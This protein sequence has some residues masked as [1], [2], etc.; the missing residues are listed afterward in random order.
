MPS[1][2][3]QS[4]NRK[5]DIRAAN[6]RQIIAAAEALF[7]E[8]GFNGTST[9]EIADRAG[10][11]KANVH[12]YFKTKQDLYTVVLKD[13]LDAWMH[14]ASIFDISDDPEEVFRQ[15]IKAKMEHSFSRPKGSKV[16]A[17]EIIQ[18]G[19]V[20]GKEIKKALVTWDETVTQKIQ[21]WIDQGK[22]YPVQPQSLLNMIWSSTQYYADYDYQIKALNGNKRL[23]DSQKQHAI[24][25]VTRLILNGVL[26]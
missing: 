2:K 6:T 14:D 15:Y 12:Y 9:Q 4:K 7:A 13:I 21:H 24:D 17:M 19:P 16:W 26:K 5:S 23:S 25:D 18:G 11:P 1:D 8:K 3:P 22:I 20:L 10:L